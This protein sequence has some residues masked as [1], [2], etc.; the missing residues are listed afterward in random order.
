MRI[1]WWTD[2]TYQNT[3]FCTLAPETCSCILSS[4]WQFALRRAS[5][6]N[7]LQVPPP[8][9]P[10]LCQAPWKALWWHPS[11]NVTIRTPKKTVLCTSPT[12]KSKKTP[13]WKL[14]RQSQVSSRL[15]ES[16][17][18]SFWVGSL[19]RLKIIQFWG[20]FGR[21]RATYFRPGP[22]YGP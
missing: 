8:P 20:H 15:H 13:F 5:S 12:P 16:P 18:F 4:R 3:A 21:Q 1:L 2:R 17:A 7:S 9:V 11:P 10:E 6:P 14:F 19:L 22:Q